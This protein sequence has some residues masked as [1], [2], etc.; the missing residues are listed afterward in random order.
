M[1]AGSIAEIT[2]LSADKVS[3]V[4]KRCGDDR[5]VE[6]ALNQYLES[7]N[8]PFKDVEGAAWAESGKP[9]RTKK[10]RCRARL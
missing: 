10:V 6:R 8:G 5:E 1:D 3:S 9:R 2:G 7:Q 4:I